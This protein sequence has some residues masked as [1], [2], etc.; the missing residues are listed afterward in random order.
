MRRL[1]TTTVKPGISRESRL[2]R[3]SSSAN[4][5][6]RA[7]FRDNPDQRPNTKRK[8]AWRNRS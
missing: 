8:P 1:K 6:D 7:F 2:T 4:D 3:E 5:L